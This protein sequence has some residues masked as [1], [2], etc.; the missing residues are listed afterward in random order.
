MNTLKFYRCN[1]CGNQVEIIYSVGVPVVCCGE[2]MQEL[3]AN[4]QEAAVEKHIPVA[5]REG[6]VVKVAVG[7]VEHPM[8]EEHFIQWVVLHTESGVYRKDLTPGQAPKAEFV[9]NGETPI[10]VYAYCNLHGLWK[11]DF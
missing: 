6:D 11:F 9:L 3:V 8:S 2:K 4:T 5:Q 10:A 1:H 7:S